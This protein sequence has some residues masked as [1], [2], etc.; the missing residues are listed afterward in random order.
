MRRVLRWAFNLSAVVSA[1]LFVGVCVLWLVSYNRLI[2]WDC[3]HDARGKYEL[4]LDSGRA[5]CRRVEPLKPPSSWA[6]ARYR[7]RM[8]ARPSVRRV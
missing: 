6:E 3:G 5:L 2:R 8:G 1:V 4:G 7:M